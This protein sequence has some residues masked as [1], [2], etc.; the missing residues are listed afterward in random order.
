M[1]LPASIRAVWVG[2]PHVVSPVQT[3]ALCHKALVCGRSFPTCHHLRD[4]LFFSWHPGMPH[5]LTVYASL[6]SGYSGTLRGAPALPGDAIEPDEPQTGWGATSAAAGLKTH[7]AGSIT[8]HP[9]Q[10]TGG[11]M[12][13]M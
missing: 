11:A 13:E 12:D 2:H 10:P 3:A 9:P 5:P 7:G 1:A 6:A 8:W 4:G